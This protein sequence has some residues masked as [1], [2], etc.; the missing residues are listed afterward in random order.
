MN[1]PK[2]FKMG[3]FYF[4]LAFVSAALIC[5]WGALCVLCIGGWFVQRQKRPPL[6]EQ[7]E[8][9]MR[10]VENPVMTWRDPY[11]W[12]FGLFCWPILV[13]LMLDD[14]W[15]RGGRRTEDCLRK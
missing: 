3:W 15:Q 11:Q 10:E 12:I 2:D 6:T 9:S 14:R 4:A 5:L 13:A 7:Q 1:D 8:R